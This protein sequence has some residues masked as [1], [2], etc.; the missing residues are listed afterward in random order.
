MNDHHA[1]SASPNRTAM[2]EQDPAPAYSIKAAS[3]DDKTVLLGNHLVENP[4]RTTSS[5]KTTS[6]IIH[7][8]HCK[9]GSRHGCPA[10]GGWSGR[11]IREVTDAITISED[12]TFTALN[13]MLVQKITHNF[14]FE[15]DMKDMKGAITLTS[16]G[17]L[18]QVRDQESFDAARKVFGQDV[19]ITLTFAV[20]PARKRCEVM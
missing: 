19:A 15:T 1:G 17:R 16:G 12:I 20:V 4:T 2:M 7:F 13:T 14:T 6:H 11:Q 8:V 5:E 3:T 10:N 9:P 18:V